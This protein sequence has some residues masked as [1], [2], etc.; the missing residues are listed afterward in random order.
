[1]NA[2]YDV[3]KQNSKVP[4]IRGVPNKSVAGNFFILIDK[5]GGD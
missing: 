2:E 4:N 3:E 5:T 1:L